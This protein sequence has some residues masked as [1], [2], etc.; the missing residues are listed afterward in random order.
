VIGRASSYGRGY[1]A[2]QTIMFRTR[3]I[4]DA[5][6]ADPMEVWENFD[7]MPAP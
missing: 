4:V 1:V 3:L 2:H 6:P 7:F 5:D